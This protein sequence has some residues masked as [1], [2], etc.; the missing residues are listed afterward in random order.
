[1]NL[2]PESEFV[3]EEDKQI[4]G[5]RDGITVCRHSVMPAVALSTAVFVSKINTKI[6]IEQKIMLQYFRC[7][8]FHLR[9]FYAYASKA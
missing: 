1:M 5:N 4:K 7:I 9:R 8:C 2:I 6:L 3:K